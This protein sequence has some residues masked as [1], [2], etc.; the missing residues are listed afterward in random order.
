M[1]SRAACSATGEYPASRD[2]DDRHHHATGQV[3]SPAPLRAR[4]STVESGLIWSTRPFTVVPLRREFR[5][6]SEPDGIS[7][8]LALRGRD[9]YAVGAERWGEPGRL[10]VASKCGRASDPRS[11]ARSPYSP[12]ST[13]PSC[14]A[15][16]TRGPGCQPRAEPH[17]RRRP[18]GGPGPYGLRAG[19]PESADL[20]AGGAT[21][22][23]T[24][25]RRA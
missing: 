12:R 18:R 22:R 13:S 6:R 10:L 3:G 9:V 14:C 11:C 24:C 1:K 2:N 16:Y 15:R 23:P 8:R 20:R 17:V 19:D 21:P 4:S 7:Q 5:Q 25:R